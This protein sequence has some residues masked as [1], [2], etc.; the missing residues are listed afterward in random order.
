MSRLLSVALHRKGERAVVVGG[1]ASRVVEELPTPGTGNVHPHAMA[2]AKRV[3]IKTGARVP[4]IEHRVEVV[5]KQRDQPR[6]RQVQLDIVD[7]RVW[8]NVCNSEGRS[9]GKSGGRSFW[10]SGCGVMCDCRQLHE[11]ALL[12]ISRRVNRVRVALLKT[13]PYTTITS[14]TNSRNII[15]RHCAQYE[16]AE[17][18]ESRFRL[19][20]EFTV[21]TCQRCP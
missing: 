17:R 10:K 15:S 5:V 12:A 8:C 19:I 11:S 3:C 1:V 18:A 16:R 13:P 14:W 2:A 7:V 6:C 9:F 21:S 4:A 20:I